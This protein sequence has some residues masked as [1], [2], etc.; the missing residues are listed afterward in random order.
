MPWAACF[1][2]Q[3]DRQIFTIATE[4]IPSVKARRRA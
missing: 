2:H 3:A 1:L 4:L